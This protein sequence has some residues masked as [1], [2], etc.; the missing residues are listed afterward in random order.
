M[1]LKSSCVACQWRTLHLLARSNT[2]APK[3]FKGSRS[4][5]SCH[6]VLS[7]IAILAVGFCV[8]SRLCGG[9]EG[10]MGKQS[11]EKLYDVKL[12]GLVAFSEIK[13]CLTANS[14]CLSA[15]LFFSWER[16]R[17]WKVLLKILF[18]WFLF[19]HLG[20]RKVFLCEVSYT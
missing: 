20:N 14:L 1:W 8:S 10:S 12:Q 7:P 19:Y 15:T 6:G 9:C 11:G 5:A 4:G 18:V 16:K 13:L 3:S 17:I 2:C